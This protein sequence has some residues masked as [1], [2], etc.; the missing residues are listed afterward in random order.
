MK[1]YRYL[2]EISLFLLTAF[3]S[4]QPDISFVI[5]IFK[6]IND[7]WFKY[8]DQVY[9]IYPFLYPWLTIFI[10]LFFIWFIV[11]ITFKVLEN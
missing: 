5:N 2:L 9:Q 3:I 6:Y 8:L 1:I 10:G 11:A 4:I 7:E